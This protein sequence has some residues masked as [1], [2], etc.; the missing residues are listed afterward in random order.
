V[1]QLR[2][3]AT[4]LLL[5]AGA[6]CGPDTANRWF[7]AR[8]RPLPDGTDQRN[9]HALVIHTRPGPS[10]CEWE[11]ATIMELA[12]PLGTVQSGSSAAGVRFYVRDPRGVIDPALKEGFAAN[13]SLPK[14]AESSSY[15]TEN[16]TLWTGT[17]ADAYVYLVSQK[18][19]ER[20]PRATTPPLCT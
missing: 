5:T 7:D 20:W 2:R 10:H 8:D 11:S 18:N 19:T 4:I 6:A 15:H 17:D 9:S 13:A 1:K 12:W 14:N 3:A 16:W